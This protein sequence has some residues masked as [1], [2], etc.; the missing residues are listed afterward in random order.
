M[1]HSVVTFRNEIK[2]ISVLGV[3]S[4]A[5]DDE[6]FK[7]LAKTYANNHKTMHRNGNHCGDTFKGGITNGAHWY[8]VPGKYIS[9]ILIF[10]DSKLIV[11][12]SRW[13]QI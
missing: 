4:A 7:H 11:G 13:Y 8:D 9:A 12:F 5:P 3:Y 6:V 1:N 2:I 10:F